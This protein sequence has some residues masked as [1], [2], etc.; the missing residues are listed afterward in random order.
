MKKFFIFLLSIGFI[1]FSFAEN[2]EDK[3]K[4][5]EEKI[6]KLEERINKLEKS[7]YKENV[8]QKN[9]RVGSVPLTKQESP[10]IK[11]ASPDEI[12]D[13]KVLKKKFEKASLKESLWKRYDQIVLTAVI[14]NKLNKK[15]SA[16]IG[17]VV[18]FDK[19]GNPLM[20][21]RLNVNKA[22][23]FFS[24]M[25]IKPGEVLKYKVYFEYNNKNPKHRFVK[26]TS[27]DDLIIK[28]Y[29]TEI[30]FADGT[31]KQVEYVR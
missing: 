9:E 30:D 8:N 29:P 4:L 12:V 6:K 2:L 31:K 28:F 26:E 18:I 14:K 16:I 3:V 21:T 27:L 22:L 25:T 10:V 24:G 1:S 19:K 23:N 15:L 5:L 13:F 20:E 7:V 11:V 17:K